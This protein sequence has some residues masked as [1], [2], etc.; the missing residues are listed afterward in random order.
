MLVEFHLTAYGCDSITAVRIT[1]HEN[2]E[3]YESYEGCEGDG[4]EL[5]V[6]E[7]RY[8]ESNP[9]GTEYL[10]STWGCDSIINIQFDYFETD[11]TY[12]NEAI[13][14]GDTLFVSSIPFFQTQTSE[15]RSTNAQNCDSIIYLDLIVHDSYYNQREVD[16]CP[17]E[18]YVSADGSIISESGIHTEFMSSVNNCDS[19]IILYITMQDEYQ[20]EETY[21]GC[22]GDGYNLEIGGTIYSSLEPC[23]ERSSSNK[24]CTLRIVEAGIKKVVFA[25]KETLYSIKNK[26]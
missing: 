10:Y 15:I 25:L 14:E 3:F 22:K 7:N 12:L 18:V 8:N 19:V 11:T 24:T 26:N 23:G 4:Y 1:T 2:Y 17:G 5:I 21:L 6:G 13:C 9:I 20:M 16:L